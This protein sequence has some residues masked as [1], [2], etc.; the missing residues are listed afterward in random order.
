[1]PELRAATQQQRQDGGRKGRRYMGEETAGPRL[2]LTACL[3]RA[4]LVPRSRCGRVRDD[5]R[6]RERKV[7]GAGRM[8]ALRTATQQRRQDA[9]R[10]GRRYIGEETAGPS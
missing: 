1:M 7:K 10:E 3:R 6:W 5:R 2:R 4:G 8:P 9:D